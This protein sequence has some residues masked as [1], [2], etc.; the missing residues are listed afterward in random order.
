MLPSQRRRLRHHL[1]RR[2]QAQKTYTMFSAIADFLAA[3]RDA[4][5]RYRAERAATDVA[6]TK[7][8]V[9]HADAAADDVAAEIARASSGAVKP[10]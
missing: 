10:N 6:K 9:D 2:N 4:F 3:I 1:Q 7:P 8:L 5:K